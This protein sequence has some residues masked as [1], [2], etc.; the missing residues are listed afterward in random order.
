MHIHQDP[1]WDKTGIVSNA[2]IV[3][4]LLEYLLMI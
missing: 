4:S 3:K 1:I 2:K